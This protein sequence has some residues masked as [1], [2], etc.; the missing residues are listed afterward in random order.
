MYWVTFSHGALGVF[1]KS[2]FDFE[3]LKEIWM[4]PIF[5]IQCCW[6]FNRKHFYDVP[7]KDEDVIIKSY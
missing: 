3:W 5:V 4:N 7:I 6:C 2:I 1:P